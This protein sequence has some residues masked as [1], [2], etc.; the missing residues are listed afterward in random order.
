M[1]QR[2]LSSAAGDPKTFVPYVTDIDERAVTCFA[3]YSG[4]F[5][6]G[7]KEY[8]VA[9]QNYSHD[10]L[11]VLER[12]LSKKSDSAEET[13]WSDRVLAHTYIWLSSLDM[14]P[15][16]L[17]T[18]MVMSRMWKE[19]DD[20]REGYKERERQLDSRIAIYEV[21]M[22]LFEARTSSVLQLHNDMSKIEMQSEMNEQLTTKGDFATKWESMSA[23]VKAKTS[24]HL[25]EL[26]KY[27]GKGNINMAPVSHSKPG[28]PALIV[29][30]WDWHR[31]VSSYLRVLYTTFFVVNNMF[32][33]RSL[34]IK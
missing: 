15:L 25:E 6:P 27:L 16:P 13:L 24:E 5:G 4:K 32:A 22:I 1:R 30:G 29:T 21:W 9:L 3:T 14:V 2:I 10:V 28:M 20:V 12:R 19:L 34:S 23:S 7:S 8:P 31:P 17:M 26:K 33:L 11:R 18:G